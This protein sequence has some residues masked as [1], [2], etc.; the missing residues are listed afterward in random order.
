M[1]P[2]AYDFKSLL[3]QWGRIPPSTSTQNIPK[4]VLEHKG[5]F[6]YLLPGGCKRQLHRP[7]REAQAFAV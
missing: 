5:R 6:S 3:N 2:E 1:L 7:T 4:S